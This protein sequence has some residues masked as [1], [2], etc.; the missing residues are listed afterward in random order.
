MGRL[1]GTDGVRGRYGRE[2]T[3]DLARALGRAAVVVLRRHDD[4]HVSFVIGRDPRI[5]GVPL[6]AALCKQKR[7][8]PFR[9]PL[10]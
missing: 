5:S 9:F 3:D 6:E 4:D 10:L 1:F 2:L 8:E 7:L